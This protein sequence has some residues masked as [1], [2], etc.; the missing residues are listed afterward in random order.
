MDLRK[1]APEIVAF[2]SDFAHNPAPAGIEQLSSVTVRAGR[3]LE[4]VARTPSGSVLV[5]T[6]AI[7]MKGILECL[8]PESHGSYWSKFIGNCALYRCSWHDG[9]FSV[10]EEVVDPEHAG[11]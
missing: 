9:A 4:D 8:T 5:S 3:F 11:M 1:P 6:H 10:P 2:F 7:L